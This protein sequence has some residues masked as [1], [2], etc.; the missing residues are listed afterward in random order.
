MRI[1]GKLADHR[2]TIGKATLLAAC[3][4]LLVASL[5]PA[6]PAGASGGVRGAAAVPAA[7]TG[8]QSAAAYQKLHSVA[9]TESSGCTGFSSQTTP[10]TSLRVWRRG[11]DTIDT[12]PFEDY[13]KN[14]VPNEWIPSWGGQSLRS[15]AM[16]AKTYAWWWAN[17]SSGNRTSGGQCYDV[18]DTTNF[19]VY[20]PGTN[21]PATDDAVAS[22]WNVVAHEDGEVFDAEYRANLV[23]NDEAC[24]EGT[25]AKPNRLSQWGSQACDEAGKTYQQIL[26]IYYPS[27]ELIDTSPQSVGTS[28]AIARPGRTDIFAVDANGALRQRIN[29]GGQ[30]SSWVS[31]GGSLLASTPSVVYSNGVYHVFA[32]DWRRHLVMKVFQQGWK[33]WTDLGGGLRYGVSVTY[34]AGRYDVFSV[35]PDGALIQRINQNGAWSGWTGLGGLL[36]SAPSAIMHDGRTW[37]VFSLGSGGHIQLKRFVGESWQP[38]QTLGGSMSYG[39]SA[40]YRGGRYDV[41]ATGTDHALHQLTNYGNGWGV[42]TE[43]GGVLT[44][45]PTALFHDAKY[46]VYALGTG[47]HVELK[48]FSAGTWQGYL[49][50]GATFRAP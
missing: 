32:L 46:D 14:V 47:G 42:W 41:F 12:V 27:I 33:P 29:Q 15:G 3:A 18:D 25:S 17:H 40:S 1:S 48:T 26:R 11:T 44:S 22:T 24:G 13:V 20:R 10:P 9:V 36:T 35:N 21:Y 50:L 45:A 16:A 30:W 6:S 4:G 34:A 37:E 2:H 5:L 7:A 43:L 39:L 49:D 19:Q 23:S 8:T 38:A 31:L 28:A